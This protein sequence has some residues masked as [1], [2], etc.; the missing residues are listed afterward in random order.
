M[1]HLGRENYMIALYFLQQRLRPPYSQRF[2][3]IV[4]YQVLTIIRLTL[5]SILTLSYFAFILTETNCVS[6][7]MT[8][9]RARKNSI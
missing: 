5:F 6:L 9:T 7:S 1:T 8:L 2:K 3:P 4:G